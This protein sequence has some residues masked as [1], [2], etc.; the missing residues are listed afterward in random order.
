MVGDRFPAFRLVAVA[1][2]KAQLRFEEIRLEQFAGLWLVAVFY[3]MDF[4]SV[5]PTE[6]VALNE[7]H[8]AFGARGCRVIA[9]S[10][11]TYAVHKAWREHA[12]ELQGL[13]YPLVSDLKR[14]LS[15]ELGILDRT[16]GVPLRATY[17]VDPEGIIQFMSVHNLSVGRN[18]EEILRTID[19]IQTKGMCP[20]NW[21]RGDA[22]LPE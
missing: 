9:I 15:S 19:A 18:V 10:T 13:V 16:D 11:D 3:P 14:E 5:C 20:A 1:G 2:P 7:H 21:R 12:A 22:T 8:E 4:T 17:V 6:L